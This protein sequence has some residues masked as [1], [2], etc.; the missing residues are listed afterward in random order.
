[1]N[2]RSPAFVLTAS[3]GLWALAPASTAEPVD[4]LDPSVPSLAASPAARAPELAHVANDLGEATALTEE[5]TRELDQLERRVQ[6]AEAVASRVARAYLRSRRAGVLPLAGGFEGFQAHAM[7]IERL[8][9]ALERAL[10]ERR[11]ATGQRQTVRERLAAAKRRKTELEAQEREFGRASRAVLAAQDRELAFARAF[12]GA[13]AGYAAVYGSPAGLADPLD[14]TASFAGRKGRL[15]FPVAGRVEVSL[16]RRA[17]GTGVELRCQPGSAVQ[18]V[19][20]GRVAFADQVDEYGLTVI[21][22]HGSGWYTVSAELSAISVQVGDELRAGGA[23]GSAASG[24]VYFEVRRGA[25]SVNAGEWF[26]VEA[27]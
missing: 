11:E 13:G 17:S 19:H 10:T 25:E 6:Q 18:A 3:L 20:A 15:P 1:M 14:Q 4:A 23:L 2:F 7:Q 16:A 26:G 27:R 5:L 9:R 22:D 8:R 24:R 12:S 21:L